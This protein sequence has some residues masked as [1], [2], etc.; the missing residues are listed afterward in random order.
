MFNAARAGDATTHGGVIINGASTVFINGLPAAVAVISQ[1]GCSLSHGTAPV[2]TG[3][4]TVF[5]EGVAAA[6]VSDMT[7]CGAV[8]CTGAGN[9][10]MG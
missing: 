1:A 5:I 3:S 6:R 7:G 8:I 10:F 2:V 4:G 9:V